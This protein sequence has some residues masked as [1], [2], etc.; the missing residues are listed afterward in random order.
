MIMTQKK[1]VTPNLYS[2]SLGKRM[3]IGA[4]LGLI[5]ISMFLISTGKAD[6]AWGKLW[7]IRP[8]I[9]VPLAGSGAGLIDYLMD[10]VRSQGGRNKI[11]AMIFVVI[12]YIFALWLGVVLGLDGTLW[13]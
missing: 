4:L 7:M 9:V 8:L 10:G 6:P 12:V 1:I 5:I 11:F 3:L 2:T 13:D